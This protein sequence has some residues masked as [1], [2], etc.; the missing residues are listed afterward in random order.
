MAQKKDFMNMSPNFLSQLIFGLI[1]TL[2][3]TMTG[4]SLSLS[5]FLGIIGGFTLGWIT[6]AGKNN[7]QPQSVDSSEGIDAA[8]KY[9]LLFLAGFSWL[10]YPAPMSILLGALGALG[11]GWMIAWWGSKEE[12]RTQLPLEPT[13]EIEDEQP[14]PR[15]NVRRTRKIARRFRRTPGGI[16]L[17]FWER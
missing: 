11:G 3:L 5:I 6:A 9:W 4:S 15:S 10:G 7:A 16:N 8:L 12:T 17:K 2:I 14:S 13:E 1:L